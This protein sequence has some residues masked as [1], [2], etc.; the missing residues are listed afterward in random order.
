MIPVCLWVVLFSQSCRA[1]MLNPDEL[2]SHAGTKAFILMQLPVQQ[3]KKQLHVGEYGVRV[4]GVG[5]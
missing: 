3:C 1:G 2:L 5:N 4:D